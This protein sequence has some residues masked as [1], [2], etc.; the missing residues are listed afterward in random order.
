M[1]VVCVN[2]TRSIFTTVFPQKYVYRLTKEVDCLFLSS[3]PQLMPPPLQMRQT[4]WI[5]LFEK[6]KRA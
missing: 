5:A 1:V 4:L 2:I 3:R 6:D